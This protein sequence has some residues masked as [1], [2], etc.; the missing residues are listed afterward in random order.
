MKKLHRPA[1]LLIAAL[2]V[3]S[4]AACGGKPAATP[5][6]GNGDTIGDIGATSTPAPTPTVEPTPAPTLA[7]TPKPT[8]APTPKPTAKP[9]PKPTAK[10]TPAP[11]PTPAP[12]DG[13]VDLKAFYDTITTTYEFPSL[14][15]MDTAVLD[16]F[17]P[18]LTAIST[19]QLV[20]K[21]SMISA[22]ATEFMLIECEKEEDIETIKTLF[23]TRKQAQIDGGAWYPSCIEMWE[24]AQIVTNGRYAMLIAH[25]NSADISTSFTALFTK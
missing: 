22:N 19:K 4:L 9:T 3:V 1:S 20:A 11:T 21:C 8:L 25:E 16:G 14:L 7:P 24:A 15:D 5:T 13:V 6:P 12:A 23:A 17:Y 2:L 10:P 18:G